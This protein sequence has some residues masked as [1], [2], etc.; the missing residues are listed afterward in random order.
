MLSDCVHVREHYLQSFADFFRRLT[1]A[2]ASELPLNL[3]HDGGR[4]GIIV[5]REPFGFQQVL[6]RS[7][8][9]RV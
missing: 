7:D 9:Y 4:R 2:F 5:G 6:A 3:S 1:I 8:A